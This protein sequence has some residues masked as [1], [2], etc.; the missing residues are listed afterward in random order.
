VFAALFLYLACTAPVEESWVRADGPIGVSPNGPGEPEDTGTED[1]G[2]ED[3][4]H[5]DTGDDTG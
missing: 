4:G 1:T 2:T 3:N 5:P